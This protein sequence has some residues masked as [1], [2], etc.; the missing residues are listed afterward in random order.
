M[1]Q[2]IYCLEDDA[3]IRELLLYTLRSTGFEVEG[4]EE[5]ASFFHAL[6]HRLPDLILLD[7][8]LPGED[9]SIIL[10]KLK[11]SAVTAGIPVILETAKGAEY[12]KISGLDL[13]ADDYLAKPFGMMEMVSRVKAVLRRV[14]PKEDA[15]EWKAGGI[16]INVREH[17]VFAGEQRI[18]LTLKEFEILRKMVENVGQVYS[19]EELLTDIWGYEFDGETRTVD[20]HVRTLRQKLGEY[21]DQIKTIRGV[22][23][24]LEV[25]AI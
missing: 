20:V 12:D 13:G 24:R 18:I 15:K 17:T 23:Y 4:F 22:G 10:K 2:M 6:N 5:P 21:G 7:I 3:G 8:M 9:G 19:R 25:D 1:S 16:S 11:A 14:Q